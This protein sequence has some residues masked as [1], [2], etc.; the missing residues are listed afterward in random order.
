MFLMWIVPL[1]VIMLVMAAI[2]ANQLSLGLK[3]AAVRVCA[4]CVQAV[5][6]DWKDCPQCGQRL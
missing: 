4:H 3:P 5:E 2:F 1:M 6:G